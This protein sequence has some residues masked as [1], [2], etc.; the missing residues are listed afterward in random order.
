MT[1][2]DFKTIVLDQ[3]I[4]RGDN[5]ISEITLRRPLGGDLRGLTLIDVSMAKVDALST[6][7]PRITTPV[8]HGNDIKGMDAADL[9]DIGL[10]VADFFTKAKFAAKADSDATPTE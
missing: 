4:Q 3:P 8:I 2:P 5:Q 7:L 9:M 6:L 10:E 1:K